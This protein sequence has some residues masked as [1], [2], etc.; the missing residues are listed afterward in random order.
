MRPGLEMGSEG[1]GA[2]IEAQY[3]NVFKYLCHE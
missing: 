3:Q 2:L 1:N